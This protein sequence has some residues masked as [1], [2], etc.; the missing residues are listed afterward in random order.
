MPV[1]HPWPQAV[2]QPVHFHQMYR[3][4]WPQDTR[5]QVSHLVMRLKRRLPAGPW[6][7][8]RR[9][10]KTGPRPAP[11]PDIPTASSEKFPAKRAPF[12][13][14]VPCRMSG[15]PIPA[16]R[17]MKLRRIRPTRQ[18][19]REQQLHRIPSAVMF[20]PMQVAVPRMALRPVLHPRLICACLVIRRLS[21]AM[22]HG[23]GTARV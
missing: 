2:C 5:L 12:V 23:A 4:M 7:I 13:P 9:M 18:R 6:R 1:R 14:M 19:V 22:A 10:L 16:P 20:A 8:A 17:R 21:V 3:I 15:S 11:K